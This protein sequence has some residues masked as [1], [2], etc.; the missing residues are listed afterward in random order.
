M[1]RLDILALVTDGFGATGGIAQFN[2]DLLT[3]LA[4]PTGGHTVDVVPRFGTPGEAPPG[5]ITQEIACGSRARWIAACA[6]AAVRRRHDLVFCGHANAAPLAAAIA[7]ARGC[8]LWCQVHG[9][10]AWSPRGRAI[11]WA[12]ERASLVTSVSRYTRRRLL[13][14]T[15]LDPSR[16]RVLPNTFGADVAR[17]AD[18]G[19][20]R[21]R[22]GLNDR[23]IIL[24]VGRLAS[25][26]QYKGHDRIIRLL[27]RLR[28]AEPATH[29]LV[30]GSGS[31]LGRLE[32]LAAATGVREHVTFAGQVPASELPCCFAA[33]DVFA[34]PSTGEGFGIVFLEAA[35]S[36]LPVVG[37]NRDG[38][39]DA[40]ADGAIGR[41]VD[42]DDDDALFVAI[43]DGFSRGRRHAP[44]AVARFAF[45]NFAR[46][47]CG[48]VSQLLQEA[49]DLRRTPGAR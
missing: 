32:A 39:V 48:L 26:E 1:Q 23:K 6:H 15:R 27:P 11:R 44:E 37:G 31:D 12:L 18:P 13:D 42:P 25:G 17:Q 24:T 49:R 28:A 4:G 8:P 3:A 30:A 22:Y 16:V 34:M 19:I 40:L 35:A 20:I 47:A 10:E 29:Y 2:R 38:S 33:A 14:W 41:L 9:F 36:G 7:R 45:E 43:L 21:A 5:N 46:H